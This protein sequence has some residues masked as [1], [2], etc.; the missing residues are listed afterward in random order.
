MYEVACNFGVLIA[1]CPQSGIEAVEFRE[2]HGLP[3]APNNDFDV[4][5]GEIPE[6]V[7]RAICKEFREYL[8][9]Q[10]NLVLKGYRHSPHY[11]L[12]G[13]SLIRDVDGKSLR[14]DPDQVRAYV[15]GHDLAAF[16]RACVVAKQAA[17]H[18]RRDEVAAA[19]AEKVAKREAAIAELS[20]MSDEQLSA[21]TIK[22]SELDRNHRYRSVLAAPGAASY[23]GFPEAKYTHSDCAEL[24]S[25]IERILAERK[26]RLKA[27]QLERNREMREWIQQHGSDRLKKCVAEEI[28]CTAAYR[29]ERL[30]MERPG[31]TWYN[32]AKGA[33]ESPRNPPVEAFDVLAEA[34][35]L[36]PS[37]E[38]FFHTVEG[39]P[40]GYDDDGDY[41]EETEGW[42]G[43]TAEAEFLG[44]VIT[45]GLPAEYWG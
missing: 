1:G 30:S 29:D 40:G 11:D 10:A 32:E 21:D 14:I 18:L 44:K 12:K 5:S 35:K 33:S 17:D 16:L 39:E 7:R 15:E 25:R 38:M 28:E 8:D 43:Y 31:W 20:A 6:D 4:V 36:E 24:L 19:E 42:R 41:C 3:A 9:S 27:E 13:T 22:A 34:R 2:K 26:E 37:A 23:Q 45:F